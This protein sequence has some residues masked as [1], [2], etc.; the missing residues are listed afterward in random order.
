MFL[1]LIELWIEIRNFPSEVNIY[2]DGIVVWNVL[3]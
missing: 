3:R 2:G 1:L